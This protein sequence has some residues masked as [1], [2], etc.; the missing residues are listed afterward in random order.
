MHIYMYSAEY[1]NNVKCFKYNKL[2]HI[3]YKLGSCYCN[4]GLLIYITDSNHHEIN[5]NCKQYCI[6]FQVFY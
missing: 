6:N 5:N 2:K 3:N 1:E 4:S